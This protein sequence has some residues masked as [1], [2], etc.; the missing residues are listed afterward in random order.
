MPFGYHLALLRAASLACHSIRIGL[1]TYMDEYVPTRIPTISAKA[2]S[3]ITSPPMKRR[4]STTISVVSDVII[5]LL[6]D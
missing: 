4:N 3:R 6:R 1:A 2:K 5:V